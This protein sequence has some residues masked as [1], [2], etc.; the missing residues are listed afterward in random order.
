MS[1]RNRYRQ[2]LNSPVWSEHRIHALERTSGFCQY[3]GDVATQVHHV[4][5]PKQLGHEHPHSLIPICD[6]CHKISHGIQDMKKLANPSVLKE[7]SPQGL[8]LNYLLSEGRVYASA[9]S[10][11][12]ALK[13]PDT[14]KVWFEQGL[15]RTALLKKNMAGGSLEMV[16]Q[17][18]LV[19]RWPVVAEILRSFDREWFKNGYEN[20][21]TQER[22]ELEKFHE[23]YEQLVNWGYD[24]QERA[25]SS[26]LAR[27]AKPSPAVTQE[28]LVE[29]IKKAVAPRL[30]QHDEKLRE[31]DVVI[32]EIK[33][34]LPA[35]RA[36]DEFI[37]VRQAL[38]EQ[39]LDSDATPFH[40][41]SKENL[42]ELVGQHLASTGAERGPKEIIRPAARAISMEVN[43]FLRSDIFEA[44]K[45]VLS[46][47]PQ[48]LP[49]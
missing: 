48:K 40:P 31:H 21:P 25:L 24:L 15:A 41:R 28:N 6:R 19:Y 10:W 35:F 2:Y 44:I 14:L 1:R 18:T 32:S 42:A 38:Q 23:K 12:R 3:C 43:T 7:L 5:Y 17:D 9:R 4:K 11:A 29:V 20:R 49:F 26:L 27:E 46:N 13:V 22:R 34:A 45:Y 37:T 47:R 33:E 8:Q 16:H 36:Q 39:A 30:V